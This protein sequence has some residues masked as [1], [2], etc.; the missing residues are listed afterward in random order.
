MAAIPDW[1]E[2]L[3]PLG[4]QKSAPVETVV[5]PLDGSSEARIALPA[6][7]GLARLFQAPL[8]IVYIGE[9]LRGPRQTLQELGISPDEMRGAVLDQLAAPPLDAIIQTLARVPAPL[10]VMGSHTGNNS[11]ALVGSVAQALL[12]QALAHVVLV[13]PESCR[14][15]WE[16]RRVLLAHDGKPSTDVATSEAADIAHRAGADVLALHVA[17][18]NARGPLEPGSIPAPRYVDQPQHEWPTWANEFLDRMM[19]LGAPPAK[20]T[21]KLMVTGGQP[22]SEIAD[23]SHDNRADLV[24]AAWH[25]GWDIER[26]GVLPVVVRR[27]GC[28]VLLV[29]APERR[30]G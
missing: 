14:E 21:F 29:H 22:G 2:P 13:A 17:A 23:F 7:R 16:I 25:G 3:R 10:L 27:C 20:V 28:P 11:D 12:H 6:A 18:S 26:E 4:P 24:V 5:V 8:R 15:P 1:Q 19:A 30:E 9:Q